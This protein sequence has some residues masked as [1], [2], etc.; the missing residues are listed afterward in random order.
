MHISIYLHAH[1][2]EAS[3][4][5]RHTY[6]REWYTHILARWIDRTQIL[7]VAGRDGRLTARLIRSSQLAAT[8]D[9]SE[10]TKPAPVVVG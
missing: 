4:G 2:F 9:G 6:A 7:L 1:L 8:A 5:E 3:T 10:K